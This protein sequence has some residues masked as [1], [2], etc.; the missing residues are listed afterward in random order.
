MNPTIN[1]EFA[2]TAEIAK[3][4]RLC[5]LSELCVLRVD[6]RLMDVELGCDSHFVC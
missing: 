4:F 1:A 2:E 5:E 6:P 3:I